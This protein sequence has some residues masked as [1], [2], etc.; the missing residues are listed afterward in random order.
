V[1]VGIARIRLRLP[2]NAS[3][4]GKRGVVKS[5]C[6]RLQNEFR[7]AVAEVADNDLWQIAEIGVAC[8][9]NERG[10]ADAVLDRVVRYVEETRLDVEMLDVEVELIDV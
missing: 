2:E 7:V 10:H 1:I 4:K 8:V 5:L 9:S 3:L 6:A